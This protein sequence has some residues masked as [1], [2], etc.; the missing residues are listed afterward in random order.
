MSTSYYYLSDPVTSV[1]IVPRGKYVLLNIWVNHG[2]AGSLTLLEEE[3]E[4]LLR[5]LSDSHAGDD[6]C[7]MRTHFGGNQ[8]GTVVTENVSD[9]DPGLVLIS[10]YGEPL[11]VAEIRG[12]SGLGRADGTP[13]ELQT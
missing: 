3:A 12:R 5:S 10:E 4:R 13:A 1:R 11:T 9:L 6:T 7:P 8:V 2:A